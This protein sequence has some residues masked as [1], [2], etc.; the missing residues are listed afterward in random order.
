MLDLE[1]RQTRIFFNVGDGF[2]DT[3]RGMSFSTY[4]KD[5]DQYE[6]MNCAVEQSGSGGWWFKACSPVSLTGR[7]LKPGQYVYR[8]ELYWFPLTGNEESLEMI[9]MKIY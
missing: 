6:G 9:E 3:I 7:Y 2:S 1:Y 5:Y 8:N 4:D